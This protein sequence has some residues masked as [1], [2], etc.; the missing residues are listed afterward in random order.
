[1]EASFQCYFGNRW[2][3]LKFQVEILLIFIYFNYFVLVLQQVHRQG[4]ILIYLKSVVQNSI[5]WQFLIQFQLQ[6]FIYKFVKTLFRIFFLGCERSSFLYIGH[7][8]FC[9]IA[10]LQDW[11]KRSFRDTL[12]HICYLISRSIY[13]SASRFIYPRHIYLVHEARNSFF[14]SHVVEHFIEI[15]EY[16]VSK[17]EAFF[18]PSN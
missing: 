5:F 17:T 1:M 3:N 16:P 15:Q 14:N 8:T 6:N 11:L 12:L 2:L 18:R 9:S 13:D 4:I 10:L 7:F